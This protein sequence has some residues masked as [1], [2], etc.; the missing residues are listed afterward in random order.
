VP[1]SKG[2]LVV[3]HT[4]LAST[5]YQRSKSSGAAETRS[6]FEPGVILLAAGARSSCDALSPA[7]ASFIDLARKAFYNARA[8]RW[9]VKLKIIPTAGHCRCHRFR[10]RR[11]Q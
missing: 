6:E 4:T 7:I 1:K 5:Q 11:V 3:V 9:L 2:R 10:C 8:M